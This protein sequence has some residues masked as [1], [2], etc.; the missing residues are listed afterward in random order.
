M[1]QGLLW[2]WWKCCHWNAGPDLVIFYD[3]IYEQTIVE[4]ILLGHAETGAETIA[5]E[6]GTVRLELVNEEG[7][8]IKNG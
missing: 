3:D 5:N 4:V 7:A 8:R 2:I 1:I 6:S